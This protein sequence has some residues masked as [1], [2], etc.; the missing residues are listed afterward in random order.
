MAV[1]RDFIVK[2]IADPKD[3]L[4]GFNDI[5]AKAGE[6]F[7]AA[8]TKLQELVPSFQK[9]QAASAV[10]FAGLT[11]AA[12][13]AI[14]AAVDAQAEQNRL[15]QILLTTGG[16]TEQQVKALIDQ[17]NALEKVGVASAGNIITA[18]SQLA[19]FDLQFETIQRLT[20]AITDYVIAEKG[21]TASAEDFKS[22]TNALAQALQGNFAALTKSGFVLDETTKELIKNGTE[23]ERSAALVDVLNSTYQGFNASVRETAEGRMVAL[24]NS[25]NALRESIGMALLP[26]FESMLKVLQNFADFLVNNSSL[27]VGI[28]IALGVFTGTIVAASVA[29]KVY[30]TVAAIATAANTAFGVS[31]SATGIGAI[32]VLIGLLI[33]GFVQ[34]MIHS[35]G[36]RNVMRSLFN[37]IIAGVEMTVNAFIMLANS[38]IQVNNIINSGLKFIGINLG[39]VGYLSE[40]NFGR[41]GQSAAAAGD[42]V[43]VVNGHLA[44]LQRLLPVTSSLVPTLVTVAGAQEA[45]AT[46]TAKVDALRKKAKTEGI[47]AD[48]LAAAL[49]EQSD[50][51]KVLNDLLGET[52]RRT[53]A[54]SSANKEVKSR[55]E[56]YTSVLKAAQGQSDNYERSVRRLRDAKKGLE[57]ADADL[58]AAQEALTKAQQAGSPEEIADAERALAAAERQVTRGKFAGEQA[59]FAVAD[60]ERRLAEMREDG[61]S[62][63]QDIRKAEIDLE[64]AKLRVIDTEDDQIKMSRSLDEARRQLRIATTGLIEGDKEL[65]PL[66]NAVTAAEE[67]QIRSAEQYTDALNEQK[68]A[69]EEYKIA[70]DALATAIINFPKI[71][72]NIGQGDLFPIDAVPTPTATPA[73]TGMRIMPDKVD[74]TVNS[75][76]VN[77]LQVAQEIQDYLDQLDRSY[78]NYRPV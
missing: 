32:I 37:L 52:S 18:Q 29:L 66:K 12:G 56:Q 67:A 62:S 2:L 17:A 27:I 6:S 19:T 63:A 42:A 3:L 58:L 31:L 60:A 39:Q 11:A 77:P 8:N 43:V 55:L 50:A 9:I 33:A 76:I 59:A 38:F 23:A 14:K 47:D 54:V 30:A 70:L 46:A 48:S 5:R 16:A 53:T 45:V 22:M 28:G 41:L 21:A 4:K 24:R 35:E 57:R 64:E 36:A 75:S 78:G 61:K 26:A 10:A 71:A 20:P 40:V 44:E 65:V 51:Q 15:R 72:A 25:F 69:A 7:G 49:K 13:V 68:Q 73:V 74:I 34:L 1:T